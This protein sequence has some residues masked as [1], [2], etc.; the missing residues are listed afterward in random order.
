MRAAAARASAR[1]FRLRCCAVHAA[2][3]LEPPLQAQPIEASDRQRRENSNAWMQH[4]VRILERKGDLSRGAFG[5]D[6]IGNA[7]MRRHRLAGPHRTDFARR[8]VADGE[9][10]IERRRARLREL[11]PRLRT[12]ARGVVAEALQELDCVRVDLAL[13]LAARAVGTEFTGAELVQDGLGHDR[14][15][16][17]AGAEKQ[18]VERMGHR[19]LPR[20]A[21]YRGSSERRFAP[22]RR[23]ERIARVSSEAWVSGNRWFAPSTAVRP[24]PGMIACSASTRERMGRGLSLPRTSSVDTAKAER[25]DLPGSAANEACQSS[26][27]LSA[28][29][30]MLARAS[31]D[32]PTQASLP[33]QKSTKRRIADSRS[34]RASAATNSSRTRQNSKYE[35]QSPAYF[36]A[37][38]NTG[39][40]NVREWTRRGS[41]SARCNANTPPYE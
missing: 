11:I 15:R 31:A 16:R 29:F 35:V 33:I 32:S 1:L 25:P 21:N 10:K 19:Y 30:S 17:V 22:A 37:A 38:K 40:I 28:A 18:D 7:P 9:G 36:S 27:I 24:L 4:P 39:S 26:T 20:Q 8:V 34:P 3:L 2:D 23:F 41:A 14:A 13:R 6:R 5:F 12:K